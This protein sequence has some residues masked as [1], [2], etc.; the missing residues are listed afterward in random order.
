VCVRG[1]V[2]GCV[3]ARAKLRAG[4]RDRAGGHPQLSVPRWGCDLFRDWRWD[5]ECTVLV[6]VVLVAVAMKI[7]WVRVRRRSIKVATRHATR[8]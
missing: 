5:A 7:V 6:F 2:R 4:V 3:G 8:L 1:R